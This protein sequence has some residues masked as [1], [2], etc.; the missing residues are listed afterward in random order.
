MNNRPLEHYPLNFPVT[1]HQVLEAAAS[2]IEEQFVR[3]D[4]LSSPDAVKDYVAFK[5]G[6]NE[7]EIFAMLFLDSQNRLIHFEAL[8]QGTIDAASVY[9]REVIKKTLSYNAAAVILAHNHPSGVAEPSI[10]DKRITSKLVDAL[11]TIDVR[12]LDHIIVGE[13]CVSFAERGL[14]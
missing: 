9:P 2:I 12:V 13:E 6:N 8:F 14:L 5:L 4:T 1:R 11:S 10:A 7:Q 3:G